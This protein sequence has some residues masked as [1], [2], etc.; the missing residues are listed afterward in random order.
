MTSLP[1]AHNVVGEPEHKEKWVNRMVEKGYSLKDANWLYAEALDQQQSRHRFPKF[2]D[3]LNAH[4]GRLDGIKSMP[5]A[6]NV[7]GWNR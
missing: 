7:A 1:E 6:G 2:V 5:E 4:I 3:A